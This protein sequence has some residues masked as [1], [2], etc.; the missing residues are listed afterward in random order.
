[1]AATIATVIA[2]SFASNATADSTADIINIL[3]DKGILTEDEGNILLDRRAG[4]NK[5]IA[6]KETKQALK[7]SKQATVEVG[8][9]GLVV[10]SANADFSMA[11]GGRIHADAM[12]HRNDQSLINRDNGSSTG[13]TDGTDI[14][15][16]RIYLSG[17]AS[18]DWRYVIEGDFAGNTVSMKGV[19]GV[20][21]GFNN[22]DITFGNQKHAMSMEVQES[23]NDIM[24]TERGMTYALTVPYFDRALGVNAKVEGDTWNLQA[25]LYGDQFAPER[26]AGNDEGYGYAIRGTWNPIWDK[27]AGHMVH[28]GANHGLRAVSNQTNLLAF[29]GDFSYETTNSSNLRL[30][31]TPNIVGLDEVE[32][33]VLEFAAMYGPLSFQS[34][35]A[36]ANVKADQNYNFTAWYANVGYTLTGE[37]RSYKP[38]DGEFKRLKPKTEFN[39]T[40]GTWGAW[41]LA[42][43]LDQLDL[44]DNDVLGGDGSRYSIALNWYLTYNFRLMADYS[45]IFDIDKGPI[46]QNNGDDADNIDT[47]TLR[48]Q[49]AF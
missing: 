48:A 9:K 23:T 1:M 38:T 42:G 19:F 13:A 18:K 27:K 26:D 20:Y 2:L 41:E 34:E 25:G 35:Y 15:R 39:L 28:L 32:L 10:E 12:A 5:L 49:V 44:N 11:V 14:R 4:E 40:R 47:F 31:D 7:E 46:I 30:L 43:R 24:F 8:K 16:A 29:K 37:H 21:T 22:L 3:I 45:K 6:E 36:I 33:N 17:T